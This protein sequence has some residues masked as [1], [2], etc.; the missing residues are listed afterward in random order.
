MS[1]ERTSMTEPMKV[2]PPNTR[3]VL[4]VEDEAVV[5]EI[6][7]QVLEHAGYYVV[8]ASNPNDALQLASKHCGN[9]DLLLTD[10]VM[11]GMSGVELAEKIRRL[12][13]DIVT[14][15]MSGYAQTEAL[16]RSRLASVHIQKPFT[17]SLLLG[18]VAEALHATQATEPVRQPT[19]LFS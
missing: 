2:I 6:T 7:A 10:V 11:P 15:F 4:L 3:V 9:I 14:I 12:Q 8:P 1:A 18:R 13:P 17:V 5:R 16:G 19:Y